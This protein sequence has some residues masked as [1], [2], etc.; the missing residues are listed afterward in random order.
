VK[1][2]VGTELLVLKGARAVL[3]QKEAEIDR[4]GASAMVAGRAN[5]CGVIRFGCEVWI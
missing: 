2:Y 3:S 5:D 1:I 4:R